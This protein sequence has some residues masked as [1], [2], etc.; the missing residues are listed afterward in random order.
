MVQE[1]ATTLWERW[2]HIVV[3]D[4]NVNSQ[5]H[6][7]FGSV[8]AFF[9]RVIAGI[10]I[11]PYF[12]GYARIIIK[13]YP[14]GD[15]EYA[16]AS[17]DTIRGRVSSSWSKKDESFQLN[18]SLPCNTQAEVHIPKLGFREVTVRESRNSIW[19]NGAMADRVAG[20]IGAVENEAYITFTAESGAYSFSSAPDPGA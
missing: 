15:L 3:E 6:P 10:S 17:L 12:P 20:I 4:S 7:S 9:Y 14:V 19:K 1:G 16:S 8:D 5:N 2:E 11:D 18:I 13:P